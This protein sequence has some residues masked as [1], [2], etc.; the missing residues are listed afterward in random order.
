MSPA[1]SPPP[2]LCSRRAPTTANNTG[3]WG[4]H[5]LANVD[6]RYRYQ[7]A[8]LGLAVKNVFDRYHEY[9]WHDGAQTLH[10]PGDARAFIGSMSFEF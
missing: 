3:L 8:T 6:L 9:V 10:S 1:R 4:A 7:K 2:C 5:T